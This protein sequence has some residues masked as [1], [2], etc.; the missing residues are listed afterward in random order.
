[1]SKEALANSQGGVQEEMNAQERF[2]AFSKIERKGFHSII[3][4]VMNNNVKEIIASAL[5]AFD[6]GNF[7][8]VIALLEPVLK[9]GKEKTLSP[10]QESIALGWLCTAFR[11]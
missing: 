8:S 9:K 1:M 5:K 6:E 4:D 7:K 10:S 3:M 2:F 11:F